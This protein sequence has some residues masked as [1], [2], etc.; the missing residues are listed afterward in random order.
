M[1]RAI[2]SRKL[3]PALPSVSQKIMVMHRM[4]QDVAVKMLDEDVDPESGQFRIAF[5][6][7]FS[8]PQLTIEFQPY[9]EALNADRD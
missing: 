1:S 2:V 9:P 5:E 4:F 3:L 7:S 8:G 6:P